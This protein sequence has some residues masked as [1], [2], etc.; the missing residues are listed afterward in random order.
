MRKP[1]YLAVLG[2]S[3]VVAAGSLGVTLTR[4]L[5][6]RA[7]SPK[8]S[9]AAAAPPAGKTVATP[10]PERWNNV[11]APVDG[12]KTASRLSAVDGKTA[13]QAPRVKFVLVGTI[14][15]STPS[16][17]R[18]VLWATG[19]KEP[20]A[21][22]VKEEVE[23]GAFLASVERDKA[24]IRRGTERE[25]L[26]LLPVGTR[27]RPAS[28]PAGRPAVGPTVRPPEDEEGEQLSLRE[29]RRR[30]RRDRR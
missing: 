6:L 14:V 24:W 16:A 22:R 19:M 9:P 3:I 13:S 18:A 11:F 20:K 4:Y 10:P 30:S 1:V 7:Y 17:N 26:D 28:P 25:K 27:T 15:S 23:P 12:M 21:F 2:I 29:Q 5:G 8:A